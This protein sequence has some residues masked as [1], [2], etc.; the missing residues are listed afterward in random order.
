MV[1]KRILLCI[2]E[3]FHIKP[4]LK[5]HIIPNLILVWGLL[6]SQTMTGIDSVQLEKVIVHKIGNPSRGESLKLSANP[7]TLN[8][9]I[10]RK[11]LAKYFLGPF[12]EYAQYHF[13]HISDM[14]MNEVYQYV[15]RIFDD[16]ESF[17]A[18][19][20]LIAQ[21]LYSKSVH[22]RVKE[23]ELYVVYFKNVPFGTSYTEAV[24]IFKSESKETFLKVF[25]HGA[26]WEVIAEEGVD[27]NKLDK[28]CLIYKENRQ[29]GYVVC[30]VDNTNKQQDA[31]Y[32]V[33]DFLQ[34]A[35]NE[36]SYHSTHSAMGMCK[37]FISNELSEKFDVTRSDQI[38]MLNRSMDYFK[39]RDEFKLNE[40]AEEVLHHPE[41]IE[42]F[43]QYKQTYETAKQVN[44]ENAFEIHLSAVKKQERFFKSILK[45]DK[46]F[47]VYIH[48]RK[49]LIEKGYDEKTGKHF[50]K[51]YF[52]EER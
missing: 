18:Q 37:L 21:F 51:L 34:V 8:D 44:I 26:S 32:W 23:G 41:V 29:D 16:A 33:N 28:G 47:H 31:Q 4:C 15:T 17:T 38:D 11:L 20:T 12:N 13:T 24:G 22:A 35:R 39:T 40:F 25:P 2:T 9:E 19:S 5:K 27:I 7:L 46:N 50:Y 36:N 10:V 49:D 6:S 1:E 48:G 30:V 3:N 14:D 45:L 43:T 42:N 52:D